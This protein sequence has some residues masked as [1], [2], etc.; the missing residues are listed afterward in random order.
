M[1]CE[2]AGPGLFQSSL[3]KGLGWPF[4]ISATEIEW[5]SDQKGKFTNTRPEFVET[6]TPVT[7]WSGKLATSFEFCGGDER[8]SDKTKVESK[9]VAHKKRFAAQAIGG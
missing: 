8:C 5:S 2:P 9:T 4:T 7:C 3:G 6:P 1:K